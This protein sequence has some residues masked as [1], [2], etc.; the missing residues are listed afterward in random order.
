MS[1]IEMRADDQIHLHPAHDS[2]PAQ[3]HGCD[4]S[5]DDYSYVSDLFRYLN[6]SHG[7]DADSQLRRSLRPHL[8]YRRPF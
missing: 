1:I 4:R 7:L 6:S 8:C 2:R 5:A 3:L